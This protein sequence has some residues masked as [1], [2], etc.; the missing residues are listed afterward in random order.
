M[1]CRFRLPNLSE[2]TAKHQHEAG[3]DVQEA[4]T[5]GLNM[6]LWAYI[7]FINFRELFDV[8]HKKKKNI[9]NDS[10]TR[11]RRKKGGM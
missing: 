11:G 8:K 2:G 7:E 10:A 1:F 6:L 4:A 9:Q 5:T 3:T